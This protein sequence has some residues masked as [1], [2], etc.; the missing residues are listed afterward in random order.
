MGSRAQ[1]ETPVDDAVTLLQAAALE[2]RLRSIQRLVPVVLAPLGTGE[3]I[4]LGQN[5]IDMLG[6]VCLLYTSD[7]ADD[8]AL[9]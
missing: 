3:T 8:S 7:A 5:L 9:V 1:V 2:L 4:G 6:I